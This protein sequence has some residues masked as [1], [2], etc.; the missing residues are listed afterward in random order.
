MIFWVALRKELLE[1]W[2]SYRVLMVAVV[3]V[4]FGLLSPLLAKLTP[5]FFKLLPQG[6]EFARLVPA[7]TASDAV[8]QYLKNV[9]QF[10]VLLAVLMA[11]GI[12]AQEK[13]KGTAALVLA[14]PMPRGAFL[15]A[16]FVALAVTFLLSLALAGA[17]CYYYTWILFRPLDFTGWLALNGLLWLFLLVYVALTLLCS[18]VARSQVVAGG[19][20]FAGVVVLSI[21]GA[22]PRLGQAMPGQLLTWG[23]RLAMG[24]QRHSWSALAVSLALL[25][26]ALAAAWLSLRQQE[27]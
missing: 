13:D 15:L 18:T 9:S 12:V 6:E 27:L 24:A 23:T 17:S 16:K 21:L 4:A 14:K 8:A 11:M 22:I 25:A 26:A 3:L 1:A 5:E 7:P 20:A 19:L 10:G 2:R